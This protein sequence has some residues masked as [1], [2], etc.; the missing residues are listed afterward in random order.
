MGQLMKEYDYYIESL[1]D[2]LNV[3]FAPGEP[4]AEMI[5]LQREFRIFQSGRSFKDSVRLINAGGDDREVRRR[6]YRLLE[7]LEKVGSD[8]RQSGAERI[9]SALASN[10][11]SKS[12]E[13]V[14]FTYHI[15][16]ARNAAVQVTPRNKAVPY[17]N[18]LFLTISL[19]MIPRRR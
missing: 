4:I 17:M 2:I 10:L 11:A 9:V 7:W 18:E 14:Y 15:A 1:L 19:P 12:V 16:T 6:W 13:P 3:R 8:T 5:S